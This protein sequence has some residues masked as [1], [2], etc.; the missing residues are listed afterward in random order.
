MLPSIYPCV[1]FD[2]TLKCLYICTIATM[3]PMNMP[4][5]HEDG[6]ISDGGGCE[7]ATHKALAMYYV[8]VYT[9]TTT[10]TVISSRRPTLLYHL[11]KRFE[12][13]GIVI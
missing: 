11:Y 9:F 2:G 1:S 7:V 3:L 4:Y 13:L 10:A 6:S 8:I 12:A 5:D